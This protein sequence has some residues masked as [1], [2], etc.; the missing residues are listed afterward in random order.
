MYYITKNNIIYSHFF[1]KDEHVIS[2]KKGKGKQGPVPPPEPVSSKKLLKYKAKVLMGKSDVPQTRSKRSEQKGQ[3]AKPIEKG[4]QQKVPK[5]P[6]PGKRKAS[7]SKI[8]YQPLQPVCVYS[9]FID[10]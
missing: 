2:P 1:S 4:S 10:T 5:S 9:D 8:S 3:K 6:E 7:Q